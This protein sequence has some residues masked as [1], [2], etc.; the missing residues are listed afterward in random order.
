MFRTYECNAYP[1]SSQSCNLIYYHV[2]D[3]YNIDVL[4]DFN[5]TLRS[6]EDS[7]V[8]EILHKSGKLKEQ[9]PLPRP[10]QVQYDDDMDAYI[11]IQIT[12]IGF[13]VQTNKQSDQNGKSVR[14]TSD[15]LESMDSVAAF[16]AE[17]LSLREEDCSLLLTE[18]EPTIS[19][20]RTPVNEQMT[21]VGKLSATEG[22]VPSSFDKSHAADFHGPTSHRE[23]G[24]QVKPSFNIKEVQFEE[25]K[26]MIRLMEQF[27]RTQIETIKRQAKEQA[28]RERA[29]YKAEI[30]KARIKE[31]KSRITLMGELHRTKMEIVKQQVKEQSERDRAEYRAEI[32]RLRENNHTA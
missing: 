23:S 2:E 28:Q 29:Y 7:T 24:E 21:D 30:E 8:D 26:N 3:I 16:L 27:H 10:T 31:Y 18:V 32:K 17:K 20:L 11:R 25:Y 5:G 15:Q 9:Y 13:D 22:L 14:L 4:N 12:E 19:T 1:H 6:K